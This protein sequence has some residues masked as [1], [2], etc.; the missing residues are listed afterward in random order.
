M[1]DLPWL[2]ERKAREAIPYAL[3]EQLA[4]SVSTLHF[5]LDKAH[6][7]DGKY[8]IVV[9][10]KQ[11]LLDWMNSLDEHH[12]DFD[13]MTIDWFALTPDEIC[14]T[15]DSV[16]IHHD[17]FKGALSPSLAKTY[18]DQAT[19]K[20]G[21]IFAD[22]TP[23]VQSPE[24]ALQEESS[25]LFI[26]K[27]LAKAT[28]INLCQGD[29]RHDTTRETSVRW[30]YA[31]LIALGLWLMSLL[32][33]NVWNFYHLKTQHVTT[34]VQIAA[35]YHAFFPNATQVISPRFRIEQALKTDGAGQQS[36]FWGLLGQLVTAYKPSDRLTIDQVN[37]QNQRLMVN[38]TSDDFATLEAFEHRL[39]QTRLQVT[40]TQASSH[41]N[42]VVAI[43]EL[44]E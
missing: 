4:Q 22:S 5:A 16:L 28:F 42:H 37:F 34:D 38:L 43:L 31:S 20:Q 40:Q 2:G 17:E 26:A 14:V 29:L 35:I 10:D 44:Q 3:E 15:Q 36:S 25:I 41:E 19:R 33:M 12:L 32:I 18:L 8:L 6:Y 27:R 13:Q 21:F 30:Y 11:R 39:K 1:F 23:L 24:F 9:M 7:Q